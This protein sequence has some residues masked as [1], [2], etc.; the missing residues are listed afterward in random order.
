LG[1][2]LTGRAASALK[3]SDEA[4]E[5][6]EDQKIRQGFLAHDMRE[7]EDYLIN[8][9]A[10]RLGEDF[11][12]ILNSRMEPIKE[13][14]GATYRAL[15][16]N[17]F[18]RLDFGP[19]RYALYRYLVERHGWFVHGL[20]NVEEAW[21]GSSAAW[22]LNGS[23]LHNTTS[24]FDAKLRSV[25]FDLRDMAILITALERIVHRESRE[26]LRQAY[27]RDE[28]KNTDRIPGHMVDTLLDTYVLLFYEQNANKVKNKK[29]FIEV[30]GYVYSI[31]EYI[32]KWDDHMELVRSTRQDLLVSGVTKGDE[33]SFNDVLKIVD[34]I[35]DGFGKWLDQDCRSLK[36]ELVTIEHKGTGRVLISDFY[37]RMSEGMWQFG[38]SVET[39]KMLDALDDSGPDEPFVIIPNWVTT[40]SQ[41]VI[42]S[43]SFVSLC[44]LDECESLL[45]RIEHEVAS[46][47]A[48]PELLLSIISRMNSSTVPATRKISPNL[49]ERLEA[50][51]SQNNGNVAI[52]GRLFSQWLHH[53]YPRECRFP[54]VSGRTASVPARRYMETTL[55]RVMSDQELIRRYITDKNLDITLPD[56]WQDAPAPEGNQSSVNMALPIQRSEPAAPYQFQNTTAWVM[57]P[58]SDDEVLLKVEDKS[59]LSGWKMIAF[60]GRCFCFVVLLA[61]LVVQAGSKVKFSMNALFGSHGK[62][63]KKSPWGAMHEHVL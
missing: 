18:G 30:D 5:S 8:T 40:P 52:H 34:K 6:A 19:T 14:L 1:F 48:S 31:N 39:L 33:Y 50:I 29:G 37:R 17:I 26:R 10:R 11:R 25:G 22:I 27:L 4:E 41:C 13:H 12:S 15:P 9:I 23:I 53:A 21:H 20:E 46:P 28:V 43:S 2:L 61:A 55:E 7:S 3:R 16:K 44:C 54:H 32:H 59:H 47:D 56:Y 60:C 58:W 57:M 62:S 51:A 42:T 36:N 45:R 38:E 35:A 63:D 49:V 24:I